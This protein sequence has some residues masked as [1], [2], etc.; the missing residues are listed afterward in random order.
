MWTALGFIQ[1]LYI[2]GDTVED[3]GGSYS[4]ALVKKSFFDKFESKRI[5]SLYLYNNSLELWVKMN[6]SILEFQRLLNTCLSKL[7]I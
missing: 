3:I 1:P 2:Q 7:V 5:Y 6:Y 4:D